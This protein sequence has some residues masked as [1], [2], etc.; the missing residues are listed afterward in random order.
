MKLAWLTRF[1]LQFK[2]TFATRNTDT[3][4]VNL[5]LA[6]QIVF[7]GRA[8]RSKKWFCHSDWVVESKSLKIQP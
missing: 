3:E 6:E 8:C 2:L 4:G 5:T 7:T 1:A